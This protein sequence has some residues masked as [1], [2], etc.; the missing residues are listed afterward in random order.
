MKIKTHLY[1]IEIKPKGY[2]EKGTDA[3]ESIG[4]G[5]KIVKLLLEKFTIN[6]IEVEYSEEEK[7]V[8]T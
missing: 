7:N 5:S 8:T 3:K 6:Q 1:D 4:I 2:F